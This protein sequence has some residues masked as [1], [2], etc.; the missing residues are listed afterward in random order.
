MILVLVPNGAVVTIVSDVT[1]TVGTRVLSWHALKRLC[2]LTCLPSWAG[3]HHGTREPARRTRTPEQTQ[4][5]ARTCLLNLE[6]WYNTVILSI[7]FSKK[8]LRFVAKLRVR[9]FW[10]SNNPVPDWAQSQCLEAVHALTYVSF[11]QGCRYYRIYKV[12]VTIYLQTIIIY[13][14]VLFYYLVVQF[15]S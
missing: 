10:C 3:S 15:I 6:S 13:E 7:L 5:R 14:N 9:S 2:K 11:S 12:L 1:E 4:D 8:L